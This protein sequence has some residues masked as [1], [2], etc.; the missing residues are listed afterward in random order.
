MFHIAES[1]PFVVGASI[2]SNFY[3]FIA[4]LASGGTV[5]YDEVPT[6]PKVALDLPNLPL[7]RTTR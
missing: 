6:L 4:L 2:V 7:H 3:H 5:Y 1:L